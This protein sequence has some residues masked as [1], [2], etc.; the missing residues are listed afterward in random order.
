MRE[1]SGRSISPSKSVSVDVLEYEWKW[2]GRL[3]GLVDEDW[4]RYV[5]RFDSGVVTFLLVVLMLLRA[6][7]ELLLRP[8]PVP[9]R[10]LML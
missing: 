10:P 3:A 9:L 1:G 2:L 5:L 6:E 4:F 8:L 7:P